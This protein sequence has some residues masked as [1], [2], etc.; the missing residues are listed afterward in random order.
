LHTATNLKGALSR[1]PQPELPDWLN[2]GVPVPPPLNSAEARPETPPTGTKSST[3]NVTRKPE[4]VTPA[5]QQ[6]DL[7]ALTQSR[8][9]EQPPLTAPISTKARKVVS[10][11]PQPS[12]ESN[13]RG[14]SGHASYGFFGGI[15]AGL[16]CAAILTLLANFT[17]NSW[18]F[19]FIL[20][21]LVVGFSTRLSGDN[22]HGLLMQLA[23]LVAA[24][25]VF[26][27]CIYG[28]LVGLNKLQFFT[29]NDFQIQLQLNPLKPLDWAS[30]GVGLLLAFIIPFWKTEG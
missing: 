20:V 30:G 10:P 23:A 8:I 13:R 12:T 16:V 26:G 5:R 28:T 7:E 2:N 3:E 17:H 1:Q 15:L 24:A 29:W 18:L 19:L 14:D 4:P 22:R 21:G 6:M 11:R 9:I 27:L 25:I